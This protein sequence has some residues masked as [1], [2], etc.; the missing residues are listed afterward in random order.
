LRAPDETLNRAEIPRR[1]GIQL[2]EMSLSND[3]LRFRPFEPLSFAEPSEDTLP[4]NDTDAHAALQTQ[5]ARDGVDGM[6]PD[7]ALDLLATYSLRGAR[8]R[9]ILVE[10]WQHAFKKLL[11]RDDIVDTGEAAYLETLRLCLGL[12][13]EEVLTARAEVP[14]IDPPVGGAD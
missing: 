5:F 12:T 2:C 6:T 10:L 1:F 3:E 4:G 9:A 8:A 11:F 14:R 7:R 13:N